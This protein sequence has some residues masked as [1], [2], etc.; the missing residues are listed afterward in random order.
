MKTPILE[1]ERLI[2]RP[3]VVADAQEIYTNWSSD[4]E[5]AR[6]MRWSTHENV[7]VTKEWLKEVER[8]TDSDTIYDWGFVRKADNKLIGSGGLYYD[9]GKKGFELGYNI[10]RDCWHQG[11]T[12]EAAATIVEFAFQTLGESKLYACHAIDN[13]NS[14]KVMEKVGFHYVS[15]SC[16]DSID[17]IKHFDNK[18]YLLEKTGKEEA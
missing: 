5:V 13:P 9:K 1:T 4:P 18:E 15:N 3:L 14:G 6:F 7:D 2:L 10:M 8:N 16:Y 11:Y 12:S 17:G